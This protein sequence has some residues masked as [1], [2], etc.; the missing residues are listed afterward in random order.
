MPPTESE[1][2]SARAPALFEIDDLCAIA[3][4]ADDIPAIQAFFERNPEYFVDTT[5]KPPAPDEA[6]VEYAG[7]PPADRGCT[8]K[9]TIGFRPSAPAGCNAPT[10]SSSVSSG[11]H[12]PLAAFATLFADMFAPGIWHVDL[13]IVETVRHGQGVARCIYA[14]LEA[15]MRARG[16]RWLRLGVVSGAPRA[17]RFWARAGYAD[18]RTVENVPMKDAVRTVRVMVKPLDGGDVRAYLDLVARDRPT[19][20]DPD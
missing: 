17:E 12:A 5:G 6:A 16:A 2:S 14:A 11:A 20:P 15:W 7:M 19:R 1:S 8:A 18:V 9:W 4:G 3:L 13:F 10:P